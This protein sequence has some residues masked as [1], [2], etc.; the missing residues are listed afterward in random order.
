MD[1]FDLFGGS[2]SHWGCIPSEGHPDR[3]RNR[4]V[5]PR[6]DGAGDLEGTV[7]MFVDLAT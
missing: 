6:M 3:A 2:R 7:P 5:R 4:F 1:Q